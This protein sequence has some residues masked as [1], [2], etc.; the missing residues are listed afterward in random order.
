MIFLKEKLPT[1]FSPIP[2]SVCGE[3]C[4]R[5]TRQAPWQLFED[6]T[7]FTLTPLNGWGGA[8]QGLMRAAAFKAELIPVVTAINLG[9]CSPLLVRAKLACIFVFK[10]ALLTSQIIK[11]GATA[12]LFYIQKWTDLLLEGAQAYDC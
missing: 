6:C 12:W 2:P 7:D 3:V 4:R 8:Q 10:V 9:S 1:K 5:D 11:V